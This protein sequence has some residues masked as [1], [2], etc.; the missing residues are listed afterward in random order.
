MPSQSSR[1]GLFIVLE[2]IDGSGTTTQAKLLA[3]W[4]QRQGRPGVFTCEPSHGPVGGLIRDSIKPGAAVMDEAVFALLFAA[5]RVDHLKREILPA[6]ERGV[7]VVSDRY[8]LSSLAYQSVRLPVDWVY[9]LNRRAVP[10]DLTLL[11]DAPT[12]VCLS[13]IRA[14]GRGGERYE[15]PDLLEEIRLNYL[16]IASTLKQQGQRLEVLDANVS[17]EELHERVTA[18][19]SPVIQGNT[20]R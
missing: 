3:D 8:A 17:I 20:V 4:L 18:A 6:I 15:Q 5:D 16:Q 9:E 11:L 2:G 19:V 10:A 14:A 1:K 12:E 7:D 13:R